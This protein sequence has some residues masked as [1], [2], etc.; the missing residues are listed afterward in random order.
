[1]TRSFRSLVT[2]AAI[3]V[4]VPVHAQSIALNTGMSGPNGNVAIAAGSADAN[5]QI[6]TNGS[7]FQSSLVTYPIN[8]CC[9]MESVPATAQWVSVQTQPGSSES[10]WGVGN[11]V[12]LRRT[13]SLFGY[14]LSTVSMNLTWRVADNLEGIWLNGTQVENSIGGTWNQDRTLTIAAGSPLWILGE[15]VLEF[16]GN[17]GNSKWDG[18]YVTGAVTGQLADG[19]G[20]VVPE[21]STY[22][23]LGTGLAGLLGLRRRRAAKINA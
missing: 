22:A 20:N 5:W 6:S 8:Q 21:P 12:Y 7:T 3:A 19:G 23:L 13:F 9:G 17:S 4:A 1:M 15:N 2:L 11:T 18:F 14:N 16:R 10:G